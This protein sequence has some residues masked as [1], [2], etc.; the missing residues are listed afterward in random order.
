MNCNWSN[1]LLFLYSFQ[2][3]LFNHIDCSNH[4]DCSNLL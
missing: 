4:F 3:H 1:L 2:F